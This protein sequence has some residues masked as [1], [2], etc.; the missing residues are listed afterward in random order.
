M[1]DGC[2]R[3]KMPWLLL[4][5][6]REIGIKDPHRLCGRGAEAVMFVH[7]DLSQPSVINVFGV[8]HMGTET[9]EDGGRVI[10]RHGHVIH[11]VA[12]A[13]RVVHHGLHLALW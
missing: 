2:S 12:V 8:A 11:V 5:P 6:R 7:L 9:A 10:C 3:A 1:D 13:L 4:A